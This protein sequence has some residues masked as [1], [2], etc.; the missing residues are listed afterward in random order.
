[1]LE[2][3]GVIRRRRVSGGR[4]GA[5]P[6]F[7]VKRRSQLSREAL[8]GVRVDWSAGAIRPSPHAGQAGGS[9]VGA[10]EAPE[11]YRLGQF[12]LPVA[13]L[14]RPGRFAVVA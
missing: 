12:G 4:A 11:R 8:R 1:M 10:K 5:T 7:A 3:P 14:R 9:F 6:S 13:P 2:R